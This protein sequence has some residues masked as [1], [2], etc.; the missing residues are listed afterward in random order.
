VLAAVLAP[1]LG[2]VDVDA[3]RVVI[4][5]AMLWFGLSWLRKGTQRLAGRRARASSAHEFEETVEVL[6]HAAASPGADWVARAVAFKGVLLEGIEVVVIVSALA[7]RPGG[8]T[9]AVV[10]A[11]VA[12]VVVLGAGAWLRA[13]LARVPETELKWG[14]GVLLT[15]FGTFFVAEG[16]GLAWPGGDAAVLYLLAAVAAGSLAVSRRLAAH[17]VVPE[18]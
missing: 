4:G 3:L 1:V 14:V 11:L 9:P 17:P 15:S 5:S 2:S 8:A 16:A 12:G 13:P 6:G 10:G 18:P 7:A